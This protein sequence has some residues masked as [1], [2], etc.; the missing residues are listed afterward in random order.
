MERAFG[1]I[2]V[3][4]NNAMVSVF[5]PVIEMTPAEYK[6]VTEVTYLG[7]VHGTEARQSPRCSR[8]AWS[9]APSRSGERGDV[10][11]A[12]MLAAPPLRSRG[13]R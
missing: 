2:D 5:S 3:W 1:P 12:P 8:S 4:I 13:R 7:Y 11:I 10:A 6:R 9:P